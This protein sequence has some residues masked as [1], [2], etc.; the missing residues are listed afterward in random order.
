MSNKVTNPDIQTK[1][2]EIKKIQD[3][4]AERVKHVSKPLVKALKEK[5]KELMKDLRK[6]DNDIEALTGKRPG[7][8]AEKTAKATDEQIVQFLSQG[9]K[10]ANDV[11][12]QFTIGYQSAV[13]R[14]TKL[15]KDGKVI[16]AKDGKPKQFTAK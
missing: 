10:T 15:I 16:I 8:K 13:K 6:I 12:T 1:L 11:V 9:A 7:G 14:I 4:A 2:D 3:A 5:R